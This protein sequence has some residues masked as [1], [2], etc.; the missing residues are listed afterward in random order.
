MKNTIKIISFL[1]LVSFSTYGQSLSSSPYSIFG[2]GSL[3]ESDFGSIPSIGSSGVALPSS[4]FINN[5]NP[6]SLGF[7]NQNHFIF[8][9][10]GSA[11]QTS[12]QNLSKKKIAITFSSPILL[13]LFR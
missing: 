7:M 2:L 4:R 3:Y 12:Y 10:G 5:L 13:L 11:I 9:V 8:D 1:I 6:A